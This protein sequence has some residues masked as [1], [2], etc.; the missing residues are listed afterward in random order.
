MNL[1]VYPFILGVIASFEILGSQ[2]YGVKKYNLF[3]NIIH[4]IRMI[5]NLFIISSSI[6][7]YLSLDRILSIWKIEEN[8][9]IGSAQI[10]FIRLISVFFEF[11]T[12]IKLRY[13]QIINKSS[14]ALLIIILNGLSLPFFAYTFIILLRMHDF[15]CGCIYL[16]NNILL[17]I[18][19]ITYLKVIKFSEN[20]LHEFPSNSKYL[21]NPESQQQNFYSKNTK[22]DTQNQLKNDFI[23][24]YSIKQINCS[25]N[26]VLMYSTSKEKLSNINNIP[27][28]CR[29]SCFQNYDLY[30]SY[31]NLLV[32]ILPLFLISL[33]DNLSV[34]SMSIYANY[35]DSKS[36]SEFINAYSLYGLIG[37]ISIS[38]NT[39]SS[40]MISSNIGI[41]SAEK[42]QKLFFY[43]LLIGISIAL[44]LGSFLYLFSQEIL[45]ILL[46]SQIISENTQK[47]FYLSIM[48]NMIDII[49]YVLLS[50]LKSFGYIY[51]SFCIYFFG[52]MMNFSLIYFFGFHTNMKIFGIFFG[53]YL[54]EIITAFMY[55]LSFI[56]VFDFKS[57]EQLKEH[58]NK[59]NEF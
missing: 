30:Y 44:C 37:T 3:L 22:E 23:D 56:F 25:K 11:E 9:K 27:N 17:L 31:S 24:C 14:H 5:C 46:Q 55:T 10:L 35:F 1:L 53:Y 49:Q 26:E 13:I 21:R 52:N 48:C 15:G 12:L 16:S 47:M 42:L 19:L 59:T 6:I 36:Y 4:K 57:S 28:K 33:M 8:L 2:S 41:G 39:T 54:N 58:L 45:K 51:L 40:I 29:D 20:D 34:E 32:I 7:T 43:I 50:T 18:S 38:F